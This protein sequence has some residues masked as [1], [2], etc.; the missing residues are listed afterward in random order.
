MLME[1]VMN[2]EDLLTLCE[3]YVS[4]RDAAAVEVEEVPPTLAPEIVR[5]YRHAEISESEMNSLLVYIC[6]LG[7]DSD[8]DEFPAGDDDFEPA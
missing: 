6:G 1:D 7:N 2:R 8:E 5:S 3:Q 4:L